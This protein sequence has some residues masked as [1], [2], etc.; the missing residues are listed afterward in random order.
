MKPLTKE[1]F[2]ALRDSI[3][4]VNG[5]D[6]V[7]EKFT[8]IPDVEQSIVDNMAESSDFLRQ[9]NVIPVGAQQGQRLGFG[10]SGPIASRT[11]T[12]NGDRKTAFVG[13]LTGD[14]YHCKQTN[15]DIHIGYRLMDAWSRLPDFVERYR[16]AALH[17]KVLDSIMVGWNGVSVA[18]NTDKE[19]NPLLQDVNIGW[20]EKVRRSAPKRMMGYD[21]DGAANNDVFQ[22]GEGST[23][24]ATLDALA[25]DMS[26]SL[27]DPWHVGSDDL[28]LI[29][30]RELW[31]NHGL[32]LYNENRPASEKN[33]LQVWFANE[34]VGGLKTVTVPFFN[35][36][37]MVIT[38]YDNLSIY[39][40]AD[41]VRRAIIDNPKR[42]RVEEYLSTNDAYVIEDYG[43][44]A[45]I[46]G[47]AI[48]LKNAAGEWE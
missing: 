32:T 1:K 11:N 8:V 4:E 34:T 30:G 25:F 9:I 39:F 31:V 21:S 13:D 7:A 33:A 2:N 27:L 42:D 15:F 22:V 44:F 16:M 35:S 24:Y 37:G 38:S 5:V 46:R 17:R 14:Q 6:N 26:S 20:P 29:L 43:K 40:E 28:V 47:N 48:Q 10:V 45:G 23:N 19:A 41:A 18:E 3:A 36:R 12:D